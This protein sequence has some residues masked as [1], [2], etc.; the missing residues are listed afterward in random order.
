MGN[1]GFLAGKFDGGGGKRKGVDRTG[2]L[3][4]K[5]MEISEGRED[6]PGALAVRPRFSCWLTTVVSRFVFGVSKV[7]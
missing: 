1:A 2:G 6:T 4:G 3:P 5:G 7:N